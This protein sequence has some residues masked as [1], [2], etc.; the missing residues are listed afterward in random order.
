MVLASMAARSLKQAFGDV[1]RQH[2]QRL[3]TSQEDF[4]FRC[5]LHRTYVS[6]LE[7]G[8]KAPSLTTL[9]RI[10]LALG[11]RPYQLVKES[12]ERR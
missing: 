7:R 10:A 1:L 9:E 6:Q 11:V 2:R 3:G 5:D 8:L 4:A 12:E